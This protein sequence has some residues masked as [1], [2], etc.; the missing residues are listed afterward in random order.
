MADNPGEYNKERDAAYDR[1]LNLVQGHI[2]ALK[3]PVAGSLT[4]L[5]PSDARDAAERDVWSLFRAAIQHLKN[6]G[7][8]NQPG[9]FSEAVSKASLRSTPMA[10]T[11]GVKPPKYEENYLMVE[12]DS[13]AAEAYWRSRRMLEAAAAD[14]DKSKQLMRAKLGFTGPLT[15][16]DKPDVNDPELKGVFD[17]AQNS[18][19]S[20]DGEDAL[21]VAIRRQAVLSFNLLCD[22][23]VPQTA[24]LKQE[25]AD[26]FLTPPP[27]PSLKGQSFDL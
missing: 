10:M 19:R 13:G 8:M 26:L 25:I 18:A 24:A 4:T 14:A 21:I 20:K 17:A 11:L 16:P 22:V 1:I 3:L 9:L 15:V 12:F 7:Q 5:S 2:N 6:G 27:K 23:Y